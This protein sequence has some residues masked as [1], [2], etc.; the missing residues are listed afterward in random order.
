M[1]NQTVKR[2]E[3]DTY[4]LSQYLSPQSYMA[5]YLVVVAEEGEASEVMHFISLDEA[6]TAFGEV[7]SDHGYEPEEIN[8]SG[9]YNVS[10]WQWTE[11]RYEKIYPLAADFYRSGLDESRGLCKGNSPASLNNSSRRRG[12]KQL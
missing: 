5:K 1:E 6:R 7:A 11:D 8:K 10:I 9:H 4:E 2:E 3:P 12:R